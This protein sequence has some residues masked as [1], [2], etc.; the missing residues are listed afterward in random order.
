MKETTYY[1]YSKKLK[2]LRASYVLNPSEETKEKIYKITKLLK[3]ID[4][5]IGRFQA[6]HGNY[7][8][9]YNW[10]IYKDTLLGLFKL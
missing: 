2:E 1:K 7:V 10:R 5:T 9:A 8:S 6:P 4:K 3:G